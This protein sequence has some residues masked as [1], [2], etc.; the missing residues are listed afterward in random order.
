[1]PHSTAKVAKKRI[2]RFQARAAE[3]R[4]MANS[5]DEKGRAMLL[6]QAQILERIVEAAQRDSQE[7]GFGEARDDAGG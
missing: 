7:A 4:R 6:D 5:A 1:M 3:L 2:Q